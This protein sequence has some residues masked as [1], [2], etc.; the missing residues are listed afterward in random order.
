MKKH[1]VFFTLKSECLAS[2]GEWDDKARPGMATSAGAE[3]G[4]FPWETGSW[5]LRF[6]TANTEVAVLTLL[7]TRFTL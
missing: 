7:L 4:N 1:K 2:P 6:A 5:A 3:K